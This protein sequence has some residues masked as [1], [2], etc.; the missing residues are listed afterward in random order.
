MVRKLGPLDDWPYPMDFNSTTSPISYNQ[1]CINHW[2]S[3]VTN[4]ALSLGRLSNKVTC[5]Y[6]NRPNDPLREECR[7][8]GA[9]LLT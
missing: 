6:C 1:T 2:T 3:N 8:C 5:E 7:S 9:P 4:S